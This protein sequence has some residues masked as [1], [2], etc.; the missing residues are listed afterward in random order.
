M[1]R[2][3]I[4]D[5]GLA[6]FVNDYHGLSRQYGHAVNYINSLLDRAHEGR[7]SGDELDRCDRKVRQERGLVV[8]AP[9]YREPPRPKW[10]P[11]S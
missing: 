11:G 7:L 5:R 4:I 3:Q 2:E 1:S 10:R 6:E 8:S 9:G